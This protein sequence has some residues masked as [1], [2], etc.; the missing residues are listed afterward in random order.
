M[1]KLN[2]RSKTHRFGALLGIA[3]GLLTFL[4]GAREFIDPEYYG[5]IFIGLSITVIVLRNLTTEPV[6]K[7]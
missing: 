5:P 1:V 2:P 4:P 6:D 3:G 7:R